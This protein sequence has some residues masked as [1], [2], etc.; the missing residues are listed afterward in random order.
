[1]VAAILMSLLLLKTKMCCGCCSLFSIPL[2][3]IFLL[4]SIISYLVHQIFLFWVSHSRTSNCSSNV[5]DLVDLDLCV[6]YFYIK[7]SSLFSEK[8][9]L[10]KRIGLMSII[11]CLIKKSLYLFVFK[12][13]FKPKHIHFTK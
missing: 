10:K 9:A 12:K 13:N 11:I 4:L 3:I 8:N 5:V 6:V 2:L 7:E 1:M